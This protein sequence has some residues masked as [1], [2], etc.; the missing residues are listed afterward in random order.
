MRRR[1]RDVLN[2]RFFPLDQRTLARLNSCIGLSERGHY[3]RVAG[4]VANELAVT[5]CSPSFWFTLVGRIGN[6]VN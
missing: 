3:S 2:L 4:V 1:K 5:P 6:T